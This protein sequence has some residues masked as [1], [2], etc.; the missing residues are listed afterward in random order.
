MTT[1]EHGGEILLF[2][3]G[4]TLWLS[5]DAWRGDSLTCH[6]APNDDGMSS[7]GQVRESPHHALSASLRAWWGDSFT[8]PRL[9]ISRRLLALSG[10]KENLHTMHRTTTRESRLGRVRESPYHAL[11]SFRAWW[12]DSLTHPRLDSLVIIRCM[13]GRFSYSPPCAK[14]R[15]DMSSL[16]QVRNL[17][18]TL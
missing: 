12:G 6:N 11:S 5:L 9:D 3:P 18:T 4:W 14:R 7:L 8:R 15:R 17:L 10:E 13:V 2:I 1:T 16:G